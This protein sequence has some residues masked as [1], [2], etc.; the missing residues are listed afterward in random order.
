VFQDPI[1]HGKE[2]AKIAYRMRKEDQAYPPLRAL[3]EAI[4]VAKAFIHFTTYNINAVMLGALALA[5][6]RIEV[7]GVVGKG[8]EWLVDELSSLSKESD[9]LHVAAYKT[10]SSWSTMPHQK[11]VVVDGLVAFKDRPILQRAVGARLLQ[12]W[13]Q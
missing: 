10:G 9:R 8:D 11:L 2:L 1:G 5:A 13:T 12:A 6:Q 7:I 4:S 3:F